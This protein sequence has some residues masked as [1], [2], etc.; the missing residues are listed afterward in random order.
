MKK[1][2]VLF[3]IILLISKHAFAKIVEIS[4]ESHLNETLK[5]GN[6]II[7]FAR[8]SCPSCRAVKRGFNRV[9]DDQELKTITFVNVDTEKNPSI[10]NNYGVKGVPT[11]VYKNNNKELYR[12]TGTISEPD[13]KSNIKR[14]FNVQS[15][16]KPE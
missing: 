16:N 10:G 12:H 1:Y 7:K 8:E 9:S 11:F 2:T 6:T 5:N 14:I 4:N 15:V 13:L 3:L